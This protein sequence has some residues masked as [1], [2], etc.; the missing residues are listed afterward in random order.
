LGQSHF[1]G[2]ETLKERTVKTYLDLLILSLLAK[3]SKH[4]Y[5][6]AREL[7]ER[8]GVLIGAGTIYPLLYE[9]EKKEFIQGEWTSPT[10]RSKRVYAIT[11]KGRKFLEKGYQTVEQILKG[12]KIST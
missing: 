10:R 3:G 8:T 4:G 7:F 12:L 6:I 1:C 2:H 9:L 5:A 11:Q